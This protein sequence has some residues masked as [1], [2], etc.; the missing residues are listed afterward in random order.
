MLLAIVA[1]A[2]ETMKT[3]GR[4]DFRGSERKSKLLRRTCWGI[5]S[6]PASALCLTV[7]GIDAWHRGRNVDLSPRGAD[8]NETLNL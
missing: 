8:W 3:C 7:S 6:G 2:I 1:F 5:S 4:S